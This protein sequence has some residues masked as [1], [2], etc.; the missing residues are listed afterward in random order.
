MYI[1]LLKGIQMKKRKSKES[2]VDETIEMKDIQKIGQRIAFYRKQRLMTQEMLAGKANISK[3]Y[4]SKI[5]STGTDVTF[6]LFLLYR[7]A[8]ALDIEACYLLMPVNEV[9]LDV[10]K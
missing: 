5:E 8:K 9:Y 2:S 7:L 10:K 6:S 3:S 4:L 1:D